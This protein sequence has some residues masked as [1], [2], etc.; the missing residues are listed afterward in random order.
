MVYTPYKFTGKE[1]DPET[2]LIYFGA[3][4]YDAAVGIWHGVDP[5]ANKMPRWSPYSYG[6]NNP[7]RMFDPDGKRPFPVNDL[8]KRMKFRIDSWFGKRD[9]KDNP[10]ASKFHKG[11]DINF[12]SGRDDF[13]APVLTTHDGVVSLDE[14]TKGGEG[15]SIIVTSPD[16]KF[17]TKYFHLSEINV[18]EGQ[19]VSE[20][21]KIGEIG[22][23]AFGS[24]TGTKSHL[25]Y[26]IQ[27]FDS[28]NNKWL[29]FNPTQGNGNTKDNVV[30][31][32]TWIKKSFEVKRREPQIERD[33]TYVKIVLLPIPELKQRRNE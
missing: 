7:I 24:E 23:S 11:L 10:R 12:G 15:R 17:R 22:S 28:E 21:D 2:G 20:S 33:N 18:K 31:P 3:R 19:K 30:D 26:E 32:Q 13:G 8:F 1:E 29:P 25:H 14:S 4:Y 16:G 6:F 5:M 9:V 27:T